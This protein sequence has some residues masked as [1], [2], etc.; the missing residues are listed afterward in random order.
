MG[1]CGKEEPSATAP[2][3]IGSWEELTYDRKMC[4]LSVDECTACEPCASPGT[5]QPGVT[6]AGCDTLIL[7]LPNVV[8][9][10]NELGVLVYSGT[11]V[12][13]G[14]LLT[15]DGVEY[16]W[17]TTSTELHLTF[18]ETKGGCTQTNRFVK[19]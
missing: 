17:S 19:I 7:E 1:Q 6:Y 12:H 2:A 8:K 13:A 5:P 18:I 14:N 4:A 16:I 9:E 15:V 10:Y 11:F 3:F